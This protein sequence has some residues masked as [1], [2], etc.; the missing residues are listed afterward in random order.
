MN[1]K[2][3][4]KYKKIHKFIFLKK[5]HVALYTNSLA[6]NIVPHFQKRKI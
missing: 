5:V 6:F 1:E 2:N 3:T 4:W